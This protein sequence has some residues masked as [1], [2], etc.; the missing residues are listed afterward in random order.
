MI[1][2]LFDLISFVVWAGGGMLA[3]LFILVLIMADVS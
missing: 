1:G 2:A 3:I